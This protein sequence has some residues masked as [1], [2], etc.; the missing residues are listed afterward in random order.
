MLE[1]PPYTA[2]GPNELRVRPDLFA[3][4]VFRDADAGPS[5]ATVRGFGRVAF[6]AN[7]SY[8][9]RAS[10]SGY[11]ERVHVAVG[12]EVRAGQAL[13]TVRSGEIARL[14][15][16]ARRL[17][18]SMATDEDIIARLEKLI[19]DGAASTRELVEAKGRLSASRAEYAGVRESLSA[20][21]ALGGSG[22]RFDLRASAAGRVLARHVA[23]GDHLAPD[24][25]EAPFLI[26]D[27][28]QLVIRGAFPERDAPLLKDG[29]AC[30][31]QIPA[32]G[33]ADAEGV[34]ANVVRTVDSKTLTAEA[35]CIPK[36]VDAR[37]A[38]DMTA[39]IDATIASDGAVTIP[40]TAVLL[41]RD[42]RVVFVK[43]GENALERRTV[44]L[45]AAV[46][47]D[48]QIVSGVKSGDR[49]VVQNAILLDGELDQVL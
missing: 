36:V 31:Y 44:Q 4:L 33:G 25:A 2:T 43:S 1:A 35:V 8:A 49:V 20:V 39:K 5:N 22:E 29:G 28:K 34:L 14:R 15:G 27:P 18:A 40:R 47:E 16:D 38:A 30:R 37:L 7:S 17:E 11:V 24:T 26:G 19:A 46:G 10:V 32:L 9:V 12:Q 48:V 41:R 23:P 3:L 42:D 21:G 6:A 13:A 45:G